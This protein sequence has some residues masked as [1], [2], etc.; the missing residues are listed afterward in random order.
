MR[1]DT[2]PT[3]LA[4]N[5]ERMLTRIE[6]L[7]AI[8]RR[9]DGSCCRLALTDADR[10]GRKLVIQWMEEAG[11]DISID[12]IGNIIGVGKGDGAPVMTGSHID[13]VAT[14]GRYDGA[15][16][17]I[18]GIEAAQRAQE[19][20]LQTAR[21]LAAA[22]FT[23]EEGARFQ[24]D[25]MG[26]LVFA[27]GLSLE[28]ALDARDPDGARLGDELARI[29]YA[30]DAPLGEPVPFAFVELHIEQGPILDRAGE[31]L[32]VVADLQG[33]SWREVTIKG[34]SNHAGT[35]PMSMRKDAGY[36]AGR[37]A[38][39][40]RELAARMG[41]SQVA[42]VGSVRLEP[43]LVNVIPRKAVVTV[44]LR[45]TDAA[46]LAEAEGALDA[47][48]DRLRRDEGVEIETKQLVQTPPVTFDP[49]IVN[50]IEAAAA[51]MG[52]P[53]RKM[54]SGAGHDAQMMARIAPAAMIFTPSR[55]G[56]SH[57]PR[58][59]TEPQDLVTGADILFRTMVRLAGL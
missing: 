38:V 40:A 1:P 7:A 45:N 18:A 21:P 31:R 48:L 36:C 46:L 39:F 3:D 53:I 57:N 59:Y 12:P 26:S 17:V 10:E 23:N 32:G 35:T 24:P 9:E 2:A 29:G 43:N 30:G 58:E 22:V 15:Y 8:N 33:I 19:L 41:G 27:G 6:T 49:K 51:D 47:L 28:E 54:T 44:D 5:A 13:T 50:A 16:G 42:T 14:G 55:D 25:M 11:L 52:L 20:G 37:I 4:I 34:V 56:I